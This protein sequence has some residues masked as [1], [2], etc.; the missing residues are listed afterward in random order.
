V[1]HGK[2]EVFNEKVGEGVGICVV[3]VTEGSRAVVNEMGVGKGESGDDDRAKFSTL[4][5]VL[6]KTH[7]CAA[8]AHLCWIFTRILT[9]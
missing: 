4:P 3:S 2:V 6:A 1:F 7:D 8:N 9:M 5:I